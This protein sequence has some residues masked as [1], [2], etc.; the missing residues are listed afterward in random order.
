MGKKAPARCPK[1]GSTKI[2]P[3]KGDP[4]KW[5]CKNCGSTFSANA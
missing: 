3:K 4:S 5:E 2:L 1:C